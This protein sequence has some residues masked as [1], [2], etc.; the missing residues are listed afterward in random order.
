VIPRG[1]WLDEALSVMQAN[2]P[3]ADMLT[4]LAQTDVHPPG[5]HLVLWATVR[6]LGDGELA[7][8]LPSVLIGAA[9]VPLLYL[10]GRDLFSRSTGLVAASLGAVAPL[11]VWYAQEAR[12]YSLYLVLALAAV[13]LQVRAARDGRVWAWVGYGAVT[14]LLL[15]AHY[16]AGLQV[17]VQQLAFA[18]MA[19]RRWR[20]GRPSAPS[21]GAGSDRRRLPR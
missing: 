4:E 2:L 8:R 6:A 12:M 1:L 13:W 10:A 11:A 16:F 15:W 5:H 14:G 19:W 9:L 21:C 17:L 7:V 18:A 3:L 20:D